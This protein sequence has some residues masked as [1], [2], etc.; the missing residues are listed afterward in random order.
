MS[1]V[2]FVFVFLHFL[3]FNFFNF[4]HFRYHIKNNIKGNRLSEQRWGVIKNPEIKG[5]R[6]AG[7][8]LRAKDGYLVNINNV[9]Y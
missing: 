9:G 3:F 6:N 5:N 7:G 1:S 2:F 4:I 8:E